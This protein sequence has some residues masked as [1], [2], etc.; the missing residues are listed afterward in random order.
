[1]LSDFATVRRCDTISFCLDI[2]CSVSILS[3]YSNGCTAGRV[4][5]L[6]EL[7]DEGVHLTIEQGFLGLLCCRDCRT[8]QQTGRQDGEESP[9]EHGVSLIGTD[10]QSTTNLPAFY[11]QTVK[12]TNCSRR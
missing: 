9:Q 1:M 10:T 7:I 5:I 12:E 8:I 4:E 11:R 3:D 2:P 6:E